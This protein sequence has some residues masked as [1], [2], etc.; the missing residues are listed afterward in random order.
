MFVNLNIERERESKLGKT[1]I[2]K[3]W[4]WIFRNFLYLQLLYLQLFLSLKL[5]HNKKF[6]TSVLKHNLLRDR[7]VSTAVVRKLWFGV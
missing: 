7:S 2:G 1:L 3:S 4:W 6:E 5:F